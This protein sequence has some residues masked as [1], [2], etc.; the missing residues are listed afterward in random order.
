MP[1]RYS[2]IVF[3]ETTGP[4][5][6]KFHIWSK[7]PIDET[8][9]DYSVYGRGHMTKMAALHILGKSSKNTHTK[10]KGF[11]IYYIGDASPT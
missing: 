9:N 2:S 8:T 1:S 6:A 4:I 5:K 7:R 10:S 11:A 3:L